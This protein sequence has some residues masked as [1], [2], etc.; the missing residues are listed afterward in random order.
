M[1]SELRDLSERKFGSDGLDILH[2]LIAEHGENWGKIKA[3][4]LTQNH[5]KL[6]YETTEHKAQKEYNRLRTEKKCGACNEI[7]PPS[8]FYIINKKTG[9]Y[10]CSYC[11]ECVYLKKKN[12]LENNRERENERARNY[13][14]KNKDYINERLRLKK[15]ITGYYKRY[16]WENKER[17]R[18]YDKEWRAKNKDKTKAYKQRY[19]AKLKADRECETLPKSL[20]MSEK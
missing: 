6:H 5:L 17:L 9:R 16:Y 19:Q 3:L 4:I 8:E 15:Q 14:Q 7:K 12:W 13:R 2:D 18:A 1:Y 11:K 10:L 20:P